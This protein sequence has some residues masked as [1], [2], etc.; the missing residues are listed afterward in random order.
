[1]CQLQRIDHD[2]TEDWSQIPTI[3]GDT[4][5][6][7]TQMSTYFQKFGNSQYGSLGIAGHGFAG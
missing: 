4:S 3:T 6:N 7:S 1:M 2:E 5:W